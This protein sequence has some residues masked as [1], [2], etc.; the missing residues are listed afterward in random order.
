ML[1]ECNAGARRRSRASFLRGATLAGIDVVQDRRMRAALLLQDKVKPPFVPVALQPANALT[2]PSLTQPL[3]PPSPCNTRHTRHS[4][5][6]G[7]GRRPRW[8]DAQE[9]KKQGTL[10]LLLVIIIFTHGV[11]RTE[12]RA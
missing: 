1:K 11:T 2:P 9:P 6:W 12:S 10:N 7:G 5:G 8:Q 4:L 3:A